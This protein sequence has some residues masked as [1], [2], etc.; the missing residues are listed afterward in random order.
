MAEIGLLILGIF[1][2]GYLGAP[3]ILWSIL[4]GAF[5]LLTGAPVFLQGINLAI[6]VLFVV[7]PIRAAIVSGPLMKLFDK[8]GIFPKISDTERTA[9]EAGV[10][11]VEQDLFSGKPDL[12]K[13]LAE[14]YPDLTD[15]EQAFIDGPCEELCKLIDDW[16]ITKEKDVPK[17]IW[18]FMK[19]HKFFGMVIP[20]KYGGLEFSAL[21]HSEVIM[22]IASRSQPVTIY[23]MVP[24]SLGPAELLAHYGTE[25][26]KDHYLPRLASGEDIP[27]FALTEPHAGSDAGSLTSQGV[28]FKDSDGSLKIKLNWNKRWITLAGVSTLMGL[29]FRLR[30]PENHLGKGEDVGI[31]CA[32]LSTALPG[33]DIGKRHDPLGIPFYNCPTRGRDVVISIDDIIGGVD[34]SGEGWKMLMESLAAGRGISLPAQAAGGSKLVSRVASAHAANRK[35]FGTPLGKFEGVEEPLARIFGFT[36]L[37]EA[38]RKFTLGGLDQGIKPPVV[39]AMVKYHST[40]LSRKVINDGMDVL[41]GAAISKGPR[42]VISSLYQGLPISITVEGANI[43]T[44]TLMIFGQGALRAHPYAYKEVKAVEEKNV[45]DFDAAFWGHVGHVVHNTFR[46]ICLSLTRGHLSFEGGPNAKYNRQMQWASASFAITADL[47]MLLLGGSLKLKEKITGRFADIL[48]WMYIGSAIMRRYEAEGYRTE[49]KDLYEFS[50]KYAFSQMQLAFNGIFS[51][52]S[53]PG[54]GFLFKFL[55]GWS[56]LNSFDC[57]IDDK[58]THRVVAGVLANYELRDHITQGIFIPENTEEAVARLDQ[59]YQMTLASANIEKKI[60]NAIREKKLP[61]KPIHVLLPEAKH[62]NIINDEEFNLLQQAT[63]VKDDAIQVD[64]FTDEEYFSSQVDP[65]RPAKVQNMV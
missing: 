3:M 59:A 36:Y 5:L 16:K 51:N 10:V 9:L 64:E 29:A 47:A 63:V 13:V 21:A 6:A 50:M 7:K 45:K 41:G 8:L 14:P 61:K 62:L 44:R 49:D 27:C 20:K 11:W 31:T 54:L 25:A 18:D 12:K 56:K 52:L 1:V 19:K 53:A 46:S 57:E 42:N 34:N 32:L 48:S 60:K 4:I 30:D 28:L 55:G 38:M 58:L 40:E 24:N 65:N 33:V 37:L 43:L 22:K 15:E 39:T 26:Q 2:L 35:Q 23:A 17:E